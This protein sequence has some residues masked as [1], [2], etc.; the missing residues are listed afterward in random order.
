LSKILVEK[1]KNHN[2]N[3][4][5]VT[6]QA[7][8]SIL[9]YM[10]NQN[11]ENIFIPEHNTVNGLVKSPGRFYTHNGYPAN[12]ICQIH[13]RPFIITKLNINNA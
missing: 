1:A 4:S 8:S 2:L 12:L 10:E 6:E 5:R 11:S 3:L 9:D 13:G 7:L